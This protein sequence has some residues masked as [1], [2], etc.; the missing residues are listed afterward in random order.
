MNKKIVKPTKKQLEQIW[1]I[2]P[3]WI[4]VKLDNIESIICAWEKIKRR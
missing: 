4:L 1:K 2:L 3:V